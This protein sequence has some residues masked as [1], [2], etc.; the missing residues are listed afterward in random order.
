MAEFSRS[1]VDKIKERIASGLAFIGG[2]YVNKW[3]SERF[4]R[5]TLREYAELGVGAGTA[6][7]MDALGLRAKLGQVEPYLDKV[8]DA[9]SDYGFYES[10]LQAKVVKAPKCWAQDANTIRCIN[11]DID[12]L[13]DT[14]GAVKVTVY[15]DDVAQSGI[16]VTGTPSDFTI[17][18]PS[19]ATSGWHKLVV[20]AGVNKFDA[21]RGKI[22]IP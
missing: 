8:A 2:A 17:S 15:I 11:F 14:T 18:L 13:T 12:A 19:P 21:F 7:A 16:T 3:L 10:I 22:Y 5:R 9:M 4:A 6:L 20:Q 1:L